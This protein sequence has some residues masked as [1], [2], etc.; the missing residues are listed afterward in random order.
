MDCAGKERLAGAGFAQDEN[1]QL[2]PGCNPGKL[3]TAHHRRI[4]ALE[5]IQCRARRVGG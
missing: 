3:K 5:I 2:S 1:R 4:G